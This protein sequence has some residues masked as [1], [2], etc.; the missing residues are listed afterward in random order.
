M[1]SKLRYDP[2]DKQQ[3]Q[4]GNQAGA[5][6]MKRAHLGGKLHGGAQSIQPL[7][8]DEWEFAQAMRRYADATHH[9]FPTYSE[10]LHVL[11]GL[12]YRKL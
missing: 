4:H 5:E 9:Q 10:C 1:A 6:A 8:D 7:T 3:Q 12:G 11:R 2:F